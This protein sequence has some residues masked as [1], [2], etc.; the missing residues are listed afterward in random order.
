MKIKIILSTGKEIELEK[1]E[2]D[3]L[4]DNF[5]EVIYQTLPTTYPQSP[6]YEIPEITCRSES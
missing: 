1:D 3:E 4:K 5:K 2:F 6:F